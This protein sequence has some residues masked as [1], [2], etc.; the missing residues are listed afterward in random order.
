MELKGM[1]KTGRKKTTALLITILSV[2]LGLSLSFTAPAFSKDRNTLWEVRNGEKRAYLVGS[3]H[4]LKEANYPLESSFEQAFSRTNVVV[5]ETDLD[6]LND[7][8]MQ[9]MILQK[10]F[11]ENGTTLSGAIGKK[12]YNKA[13]KKALEAGFS[14]ATMESFQP[15]FVCTTIALMKMVQMGYRADYG[16]DQYFF[17]KAK[18]ANKEI[19]GLETPMEQIEFLSG[20]S[21]KQQKELFVQTIE[22][23]DVFEKNLD[24]LVTYW[25]QG[26]VAKLETILLESFQS[27]QDV[28]D[29]VVKQRNLNWLPKIDTL[30]NGNQSA[31]IVVGAAHLVGKDGLVEMLKSKGYEVEQR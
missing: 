16:V 20:M 6:K 8:G 3:I 14:L 19:L 21:Q 9:Q 2:S 10:A 31:M 27:H 18:G 13:E 4:M 17:N 24:E 15:W 26:D 30:L 22:D 25:E 11:A 23:L 12:A 28:Y 29:R 5:F 1:M 7:P